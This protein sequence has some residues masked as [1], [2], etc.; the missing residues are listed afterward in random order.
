[1]S[2]ANAAATLWTVLD[3]V[4]L[5]VANAKQITDNHLKVTLLYKQI[6]ARRQDFGALL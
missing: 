5:L 4:A 2:W 6:S 1:M 3:T